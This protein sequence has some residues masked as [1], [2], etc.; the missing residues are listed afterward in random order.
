MDIT[1]KINYLGNE[2]SLCEALNKGYVK[3]V[4]SKIIGNKNIIISISTKLLDWNN[5]EIFENDIVRDNQGNIYKI[6]YNYGMFYFSD[7]KTQKIIMP[8]SV[9]KLGNKIDIEVIN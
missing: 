9:C 1:I 7:P 3:I 4:D 5:K 8:I 2:I 6:I